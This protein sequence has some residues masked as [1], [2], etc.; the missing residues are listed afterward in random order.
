MMK[1]KT[2]TRLFSGKALPVVCAVFIMAG[3]L[4][5]KDRLVLSALRAK[6]GLIHA[7]PDMDVLDNGGNALH[8]SRP[9]DNKMSNFDWPDP[10]DEAA[11]GQGPE[12]EA[13]AVRNLSVKIGAVYVIPSEQSFK[14]IY[15][16]G[17]GL[18]GEFNFGLWKSVDMWIFGNYYR[19]DGSL[20]VTEEATTLSLLALGGGPKFRL[21]RAGV[22]P[23][24]GVGAVLYVYK[25]ENPIGLAEGT[26]LGFVGQVGLSVQVVGGLLLDAGLNYTY[27]QVQPQNIKANVGGLQLGLSLGYSF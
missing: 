24:F 26:G 27:C 21:S 1:A 3:F 13:G 15:G 18:G 2:R 10:K 6:R 20:P 23:Y 11:T 9:N 22:S 4:P 17:I 16:S 12:S 19:S 7:L 14:E 8:L 5:A 25:E